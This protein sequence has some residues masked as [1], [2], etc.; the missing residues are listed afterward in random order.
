MLEC[1]ANPSADET[2]SLGTEL[3]VFSL[4]LVRG[5]EPNRNWLVYAHSPLGDRSGVKVTVPGYREI[6]IDS[7]VGGSF[8]TVQEKTGAIARIGK[9]R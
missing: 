3:P 9:N 2:L 7:A 5:E 1:D 8:H 4:A 6:T